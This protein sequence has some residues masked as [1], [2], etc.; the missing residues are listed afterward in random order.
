[1]FIRT[2]NRYADVKAE[3]GGMPTVLG[4]SI[5]MSMEELEVIHASKEAAEE[6]EIFLEK[7]KCGCTNYFVKILIGIFAVLTL[8]FVG[9]SFGVR[10]GGGSAALFVLAIFSLITS[11][12]CCSILCC[13]CCQYPKGQDE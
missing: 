9:A 5:R 11:I 12:V 7:N 1:M 13:A 10:D 2:V 4:G 6:E 8:I 3:F